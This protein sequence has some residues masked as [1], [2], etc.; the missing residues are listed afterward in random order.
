MN[1]TA[2][3]SPPGAFHWVQGSP[4]PPAAQAMVLLLMPSTAIP[5]ATFLASARFD[6]VDS[7]AEK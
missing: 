5:A 2:F 6:K 1:C 7:Q 3:L 4:L